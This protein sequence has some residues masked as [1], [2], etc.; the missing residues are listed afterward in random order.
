MG[1]IAQADIPGNI[2]SFRYTVASCASNVSSTTLPVCIAPAEGYVRSAN[3]QF[4]VSRASST[5]DYVMTLVNCGSVGTGTTVLGTFYGSAAFVS[6]ASSPLTVGA[7]TVATFAAGDALCLV[8][9]SQAATT[10]LPACELSL[11]LTYS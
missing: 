11:N 5:K 3:L 9:A 6:Y 7:S 8:Q 1:K 4:S 10:T 2:N